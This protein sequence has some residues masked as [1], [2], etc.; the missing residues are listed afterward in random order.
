MTKK[1]EIQAAYDERDKQIREE[2]EAAYIEREDQ[3]DSRMMKVLM[4]EIEREDEEQ[5][6]E[7]WNSLNDDESFLNDVE[8][9]DKLLTHKRGSS[10]DYESLTLRA[11]MN[12][13]GDSLGFD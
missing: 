10:I 5:D 11:I 13:Y 7:D 6:D 1:E 9:D 8:E 3:E 12:G 4:E 2:M